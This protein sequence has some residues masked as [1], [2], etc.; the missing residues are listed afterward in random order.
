M[1]IP[2]SRLAASQCPLHKGAFAPIYFKKNWL[3]SSH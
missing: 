2:Q 1:T 3:H